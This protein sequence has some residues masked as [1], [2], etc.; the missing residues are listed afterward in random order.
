MFD[1][2]PMWPLPFIFY[3]SLTLC[4]CVCFV[5]GRCPTVCEL[6]IVGCWLGMAK[7]DTICQHEMNL[8]RFLWVWVEFK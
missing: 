6:V 2:S 1:E 5:L 8:T 7:F 3:F 4:V